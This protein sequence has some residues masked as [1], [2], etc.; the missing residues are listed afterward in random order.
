M[1]CALA[2][3]V[4]AGCGGSAATT[5]TSTATSPPAPSTA[6]R[7]SDPFQDLLAATGMQFVMP[8]GFSRVEVAANALWTPDLAIGD[9]TVE[10]HY[11]LIPAEDG[12]EARKK[13]IALTETLCDFIGGVTEVPDG[14]RLQLGADFGSLAVCDPKPDYPARTAGDR[15]ALVILHKDGAGAVLVVFFAPDMMAHK[16]TFDRALE[17][18]SFQ[19]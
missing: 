17:A 12:W 2:L 11:A 3:V 9:G 15:A 13:L 18:L 5:P 4:V 7:A 8:A 10:L 14:E 19:P 16:D 1:K 6:P